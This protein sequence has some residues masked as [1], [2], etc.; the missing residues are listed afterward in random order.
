M[1][2][3]SMVVDCFVSLGISTIIYFWAY[4]HLDVVCWGPVKSP[5]TFCVQYQYFT[6]I[7]SYHL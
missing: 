2:A 1:K 6:P 4:L 7:L 5:K 3:L